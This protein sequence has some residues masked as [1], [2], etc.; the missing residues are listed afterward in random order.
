[1]KILYRKNLRC[2]R[3]EAFLGMGKYARL[4]INIHMRMHL[5]EAQQ[6]SREKQRGNAAICKS[7]IRIGLVREL[8][9]GWREDIRREN[10][11][12]LIFSE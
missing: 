9:D 5:H 4:Y 7:A 3:E 12:G 2:Y 10:L 6:I 8:C 11:V 1:M